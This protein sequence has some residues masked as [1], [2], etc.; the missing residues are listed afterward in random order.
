MRPL[1]TAP[2]LLLSL[3]RSC[4]PT[5]A[6]DVEGTHAHRIVARAATADQLFQFRAEGQA[7]G[8]SDDQKTTIT[9]WIAETIKL[10]NAAL[11]AYGAKSGLPDV[12]HLSMIM[13]VA[14][15]PDGGFQSPS[16]QTLH[17]NIGNRMAAVTQFLSGQGL[18]NAKTSE[19]PYFFCDDSIATYTP[20]NQPARNSQGQTIPDPDNEGDLVTVTKLF[21]FLENTVMGKY[22][23]Q[24]FYMDLFNAYNFH[25]TNVERMCF[26][27]LYAVTPHSYENEANGVPGV[28]VGAFDRFIVFCNQAYSPAAGTAHSAASLDYITSYDGYPAGR[29]MGGPNRPR[30]DAFAPISGTF[31]HEL[32]H[33]TDT[34]ATTGDPEPGLDAILSA[35][36]ARNSRTQT[37]R[38]MRIADNPESF[39]MFAV[40]S[41]LYRNPPTTTPDG[42]DKKDAVIF[43]GSQASTGDE[44]FPGR[45]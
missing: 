10:H 39:L 22:D 12:V 1:L 26:D 24:P 34:A 44:A 23:T 16:D 17:L 38:R 19:K 20:W 37:A 27:T 2:L 21:P 6:R 8:C 14:L 30:L 33:L 32:F 7:G 9:N 35:A 18:Q 40:A 41:Y 11:S 28:T 25:G 13:G 45:S 43:M 31:Y 29:V 3:F 42:S 5:L 36:M 4:Q 15:N